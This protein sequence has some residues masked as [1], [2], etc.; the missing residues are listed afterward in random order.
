VTHTFPFIALVA[1]I[2]AA[3]SWGVSDFIAA[4]ASKRTSPLLISLLVLVTGAIAYSFIYFLGLSHHH[5]WSAE[6][7]VLGAASG[8]LMTLALTAYYTGLS[9]GPVSIVSPIGAAYPLITTLL[10]ILLFKSHL[11][12]PQAFGIVLTVSGIMVASG[13]LQNKLSE[14]RLNM[15]AIW[16]IVA[17]LFWGLL[18]ALLGKAI[19]LLGWQKG[20]L[21]EVWFTVVG[22]LIALPFVKLKTLLTVKSLKVALNKYVLIVSALQLLGVVALNLGFTHTTSTA[23]I[24]TIS[25]CYPVLTVVLAY[26]FFKERL[27]LFTK[28]GV[29]ATIVGVAII[30]YF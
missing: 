22:C 14:W 4:K 8:L 16:A 7:I 19:S 21:I 23:V 28:F 26:I 11:T 18:F 29:V 9:I 27:N 3:V 5:M 12:L 17:F 6:G 25:A 20:S 24:I 2:T 1:G 13:L 10:V 30:S 15:G